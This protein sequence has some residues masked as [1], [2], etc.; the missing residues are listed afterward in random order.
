M[1]GFFNKILIIN[2]NDK[3]TEL[4]K[5]NNKIYKNNLGGKG[6]GT[7]LLLMYNKK[8]VNP[9]DEDN[10]IIFSTGP[11]S[12]S[13]IFGSSRYGV[14][15]KSPLTGIYGESYSGGTAVLGMSRTGYDA[16]IIHG[17]S[18]KPLWLDI[19]DDKVLFNNAEDIWGLDT[20]K[21]EEAISSKLNIRSN[22]LVIGPAGENLVRFAVIKND[23][24][25]M[26]GR[27]GMGAVLGSKKIKAI[28]FGGE[29]KREFF[30]SKGIKNYAKATF[31]NLKDHN[32]T[33]AYKSFGTPMSVEILNKNN[34]FPTRYWQK[35]V[36][37]NWQNIDAISMQENLRVKPHACATCFLA[38][39]KMTEITKGRH[40][41]L[42]LEGPEYETLYSFG[43]LCEIGKIDEIAYLNNIC[44]SLGIDTISGG[45]L[46]ALAIEAYKRGKNKRRIEYGAVDSIAKFL[47]DIVYRKDDG[48][49]FAEG[50]KAVGKEL[51]MEEFTVH[52]KGMEP[53]GYDPRVLKGMGLSYAVNERGACHLR[54]TFYKPELSGVIEPEKTEGKARIFID[55]EDRATL[56]DSLILCRFYRDFY[57]WNE[58]SEIIGLATG[59]SLDKKE[60]INIA[61]NIKDNTRIFNLREGMTYKADNLP[62]R[63][64]NEA[65][66]NG[67]KI[68]EDELL[69]MVK[70]YYKLRGW[71]T[72]GVPPQKGFKP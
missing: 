36:Y 68:T 66:E 8:G 39:G 43:G 28:S 62:K 31:K 45:N 54:S 57:L 4:R 60:L 59:L 3:T 10:H 30:D 64:Y 20:F 2:L 1:K 38:C 29:T 5:I 37:E 15:T 19:R 33:L 50:I 25:R 41:G 65:L 16:I 26:A 47:N 13:R 40:K 71:D 21:T 9:F 70:D 14:F 49:I 23:G 34:A 6:L 53:A 58:L 72:K 24:W 12:D 22:I 51:D 7:Y 11:L 18:K 55:Y 27:T 61:S 69:Y 44:D 63:F 48:N 52:V 46:A 17:K 32:T 56:F 67:A 35:G 42:K